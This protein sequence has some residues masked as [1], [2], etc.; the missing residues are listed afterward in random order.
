MK[1]LLTG[2]AGFIGSH[3]LDRLVA[4]GHDVVGVDNFDPFYDRSLK[5][6]NIAAHMTASD[7]FESTVRVESP[8][9]E[10]ATRTPSEQV[11][12]NIPPKGSFE[13]LEADL[14]EPETYTKLKF[15][16]DS[17]SSSPPA[18]GGVPAGRAGSD[19]SVIS[20]QQSKAPLLML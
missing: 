10:L 16:A 12:S 8:V 18:Q 11:N 13:L 5:N 9:N 15:L 4:D 20:H 1:I 17:L 14:A 19:S 7:Q 2:C 3:A 6:A